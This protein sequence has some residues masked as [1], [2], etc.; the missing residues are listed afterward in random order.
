MRL[1]ELKEAK[2][3]MMKQVKDFVEGVS[4]ELSNGG[5]TWLYDIHTSNRMWTRGDGSRY[6]DW[7]YISSFY[8]PQQYEDKENN[9]DLKHLPDDMNTGSDVMKH[10]WSVIES[11]GKALGKISDEFPSIPRGNAVLVG[12]IIFV[13]DNYGSIKF[14]SKSRLKNS[15]VWNIKK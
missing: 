12:S 2:G 3:G 5:T 14:G 9:R 1:Q 13:L 11:K 7:P 6:K 4:K 10:L 8:E 15:D